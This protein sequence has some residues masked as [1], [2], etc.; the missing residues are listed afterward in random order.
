MTEIKVLSGQSYYTIQD[1]LK[2]NLSNKSHIFSQ[3]IQFKVL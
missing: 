3:I 1:S 2:T